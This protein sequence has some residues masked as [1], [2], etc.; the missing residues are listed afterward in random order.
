[1]SAVTTPE[2]V[3]KTRGVPPKGASE[4]AE[5]AG[6]VTPRFLGDRPRNRWVS[7]ALRVLVP[8]GLLAL[9]W[10]LSASET[11]SD[12]VLASPGS[13]VT[14]FRELWETGQLTD[15]AAASLKRAGL[16]VLFGAGAGVLLG[17]VSGFSRLGEELIDTTMQMKRVV[18]FLALVPL[19]IS[20]FGVGETFKIVLIAVSASAPMYAYTYLGVRGVDRK[21]V[22]A[23]RGFGLTGPRLALTLVLPSALPNILMG[24]RISLGISLTALIAAEQVGTTEGIGY[25][26]SL[27]Q[28]YYRPDYMILC[29]VL[30]ALLGLVVDAAIRLVE[31][32]AM[33]W[34]RHLTLR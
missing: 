6:L 4:A 14:A 11:V 18:P 24:L 9:W 32:V 21:V 7:L 20:W 26:V 31:R 12:D 13:V 2:A 19:F 10:W 29:V 8:F 23:A 27:G 16:G 34:R 28:Q 17:L 33:P 1:M 3:A 25:L 22:E 5:T 15:Y 30:Y